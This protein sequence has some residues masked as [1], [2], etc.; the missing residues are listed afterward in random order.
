MIKKMEKT[1]LLTEKWTLEIRSQTKWFD[2]NITELWYY[3]DLIMMFVRRDFVATYKQTILGPLWFLIG[4]LSSTIVFT[5]IFGSVA[6]IPTDGQPPF[7]FYL[8]GIVTWSYFANCMTKTSNTFL[9]NAGIFGK[10]YFPRLVVPISVVISNLVA[11]AI[12]FILFIIFL[13]YFHL[14][15]TISPPTIFILLMPLLLIQMAALGLGIGILISSMTTKYRDLSFALTFGTQ[16]WMYAT[17]IVYPLSQIPEEWHWLFALNPMTVII[18]AFR[19]SFLGCGIVEPWMIY[20][21]VS[22]TGLILISGILFFN[23]IEKNFVDT[24]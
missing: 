22:I 19:Y 18:E 6:K 10:V 23:R 2:I 17:P 1:D 21:S 12:Q 11:F 9:E 7:L 3:R 8:S 4:P 14:N 20:L 13:I 24:I 16:L 15:A 5:V